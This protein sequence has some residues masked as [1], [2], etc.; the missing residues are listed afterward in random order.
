MVEQLKV[1]QFHTT[2]SAIR[3]LMKA[4]DK[5][6]KDYDLSS[7]KTIGAGTQ[8]SDNSYNHIQ[9]LAWINRSTHPCSFYSYSMDHLVP[10]IVSTM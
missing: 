2:P 6:V 1:N 7:L 3:M 9:A 4:G 8:F 10:M 5:Y